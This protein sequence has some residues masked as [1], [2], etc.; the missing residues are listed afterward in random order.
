MVYYGWVVKGIEADPVYGVLK[1]ALRQIPKDYPFRGPKKYKEGDF[2][3]TNSWQGKIESFSGEEQI[4]QGN[5]LI[6][7]AN[8]LGG[9]VDQRKGV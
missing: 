2:V 8:Y 6:Y 1:N 4:T 7:K 5:K 3:Y 9:L